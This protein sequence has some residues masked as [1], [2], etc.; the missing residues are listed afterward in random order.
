[1][2][3]ETSTGPSLI[4]A[5]GPMAAE[6]KL[7][8]RVEELKAPDPESLGTSIRIVV[9]SRSLRRHLLKVLADRFGAV[10]GVVVQ[11]HRALALEVLERA[12]VELP[13]GGA[14]VQDILAR[15]FAA[16]EEAL[17]RDLADFD[18]G[19]A[20]V[21]GAVRDLLDAGFG[22][23]HFEALKDAVFKSVPEEEAARAVSVAKV[24]ATCEVAVQS[25]GFG[26][27]GTLHELAS[28]VVR[29]RGE[30]VL[31]SRAILIHGFAEATGLLSD[32][33]ESLVRIYSA[34]VI[35]DHPPDP[36]KSDL[37]DPGRRFTSR[38]IQRLPGMLNEWQFDG[39]S[40]VE[41]E[42][43]TAPGPD[44]EIREV[45]SRVLRLKR[46]GVPWE[47]IAIVQRSLPLVT[48][49]AVR[50]HFAR[51]AIPFSGE[52]AT[53]EGGDEA[54]RAV[55][56]DQILV[57]GTRAS[58]GAWFEAQNEGRSLSV[59]ELDLAL[60]T[61][62]VSR[63]GQLDELDLGGLIDGVGLK[64]PVVDRVEDSETGPKR[65][66]RVVAQSRLE[67]LVSRA[68]VLIDVVKA[69][70]EKATV[71]AF[72]EWTGDVLKALTWDERNELSSDP[73]FRA[74][75]QLRDELPID[76]EIEWSALQPT[77]SRALSGMGA[78]PLGGQGGGVQVLTVMEARGRTFDH[79]FIMGLNRGVF[80]AG[81]T[82]DPVF[83][84][85]ARDACLVLLPDLPTK[86]RNRSDEERYL[87]AQLMAAAPAITISWQRIDADGKELNPSVFIERLR[88]AGVVS[89]DTEGQTAEG[90]PDGRSRVVSAP[91]VFEV[92][93]SK[94]IR[95]AVEYAVIE[96]LGEKRS[97]GFFT[98][99][100]R[101][102][103][104]DAHHLRATLD[105]IDPPYDRNT[106]GPFL[107]LVGLTPPE[108]IWVTRLE[109]H[110][111]CPWKAF[112]QREL[113]LEPPPEA[114]FS[115]E[116]VGGA[117]VGSVV[118]AVLEELATKG[119]VTSGSPMIDVCQAKGTR[120]LWASDGVLRPMIYQHARQVAQE[121]G[122]LW[123][124]PAIAA[125]SSGYFDRVRRLSWPAEA[126]IAG[127]EARGRTEFE[128]GGSLGEQG[129]TVNF[130]VDRVDRTPDGQELI[131]I[132]YK[133]GK[134]GSKPSTAIP[135]GK[136]LQGAAYAL[137]EPNVEFGRY[138]YLAEGVK[139]GAEIVDVSPDEARSAIEVVRAV[140]GSWRE[141]VLFP[142]L[143]TP[144][145]SGE[146]EG[147]R[148]CDLKAACLHGDSGVRGRMVAAFDAMDDD[149]PLRAHWLLPDVGKV[150]RRSDS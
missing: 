6:E 52:G 101:I 103:G 105:E 133:T 97:L 116:G 140:V 146:G 54:R 35:V 111:Q 121:Q 51:L 53:A 55:A 142:R 71:G 145:G 82:E 7:L 66:R 22:S 100:D 17:L 21:A 113:G 47:S 80:P 12:G 128:P 16:G 8:Q 75:L 126:V 42:A 92:G 68:A 104:P 124:W 48:V 112:L 94:E 61:L 109:A 108:E 88:L 86:D 69:R 122:A 147:C 46:E 87:F 72:F 134:P 38:L 63:L 14:R 27:R 131:L 65:I 41:I 29:E 57:Q 62:G 132:D 91:D 70:P 79:L 144:D 26:H 129:T 73:V 114:A 127:V 137:S 78:V 99:V 106:L 15:R 149:Q 74:L 60:R 23:G 89:W 30:A 50:R 81:V 32:L 107:G 4:L 45:G 76:L 141:G 56:F 125:A 90:F 58:V 120:V 93:S 98:A 9:P 49:N 115:D 85:R 37:P 95:P 25:M 139:E 18:D 24:A 31:P 119:G 117:M 130:K 67:E 118:H 2:P 84:S 34:E 11:T 39:V 3:I 59:C 135:R 102:G 136:L 33:L 96:G 83:S 1:M 10:V 5:A 110:I 143:C 148:W 20:S 19:F 44:A 40:K 64:L 150:G 138:V 77:V 28:K 36:S 43:F 13:E 123:I